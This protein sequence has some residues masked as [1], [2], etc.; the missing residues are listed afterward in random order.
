METMA[1]KNC[2][3]VPSKGKRNHGVAGLY[4]SFTP[5]SYIMDGE[6]EAQRHQVAS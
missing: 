4:I 2:S 1:F 5:N 3:M 6:T